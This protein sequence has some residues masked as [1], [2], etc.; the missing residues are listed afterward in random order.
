MCGADGTVLRRHRVDG[1]RL[2][3]YYRRGQNAARHRAARDLAVGPS[4]AS[5]IARAVLTADNRPGCALRARDRRCRPTSMC[6]ASSLSGL[7]SIR[8]KCISAAGARGAISRRAR[9]V[10][11]RLHGELASLLGISGFARVGGSRQFASSLVGRHGHGGV[12]RADFA[13]RHGRARRGERRAR[14]YLT[15]AATGTSVKHQVLRRVAGF[16]SPR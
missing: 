13:A 9:V 7:H 14:L 1:I 6:S 4:R 16:S 8:K 10:V 2:Q 5:V 11:L 3:N 15:I 12:S